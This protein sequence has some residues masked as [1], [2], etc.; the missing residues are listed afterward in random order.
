[1]VVVAS[2]SSKMI[3]L[4]DNDIIAFSNLSIWRPFSKVIIFYED[5]HPFWSF[6][7]RW[8]LKTQRKVF[9]FDENV[10]V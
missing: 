2:F 5:D 8:K 9:G 4:H 1:M 3:R 10:F 7:C 6:S